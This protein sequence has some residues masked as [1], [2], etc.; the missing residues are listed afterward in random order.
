MAMNQ[1]LEEHALSSKAQQEQV[2]QIQAKLDLSLLSLGQVQQDQGQ[3][4]SQ[5]Q[6]SQSQLIKVPDQSA[7]SIGVT[8][9]YPAIACFSIGTI[10]GSPPPAVPPPAKVLHVPP[11]P[12]TVDLAERSEGAGRRSWLP[13][14]EFPRFDGA[15][16]RVWVDTCNT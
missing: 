2:Q 5:L 13:K 14:M 12:I 1:R 7:S 8:K 16:A 11:T 9:S 3:V 10:S 4:M 6:S 15:N